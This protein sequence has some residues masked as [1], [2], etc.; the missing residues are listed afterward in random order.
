ME[1]H[2]VYYMYRAVARSD[3]LRFDVTAISPQKIGDEFP[4]TFGHYHPI[5]EDGLAYP[6]IYQ[7]LSGNAT[8][9]LQKMNSDETTDVIIVSANQG[10][11]VLLPPGYGHVSINSGGGAL[12][13]KNIVYDKFES[14]YDEYR[15]NRGAAIYY[16]SDRSIA[17]NSAYVIKNIERLSVTELNKKLGFS[18]K[19]LL[20]ELTNDPKKFEFLK[21]PKLLP[22]FARI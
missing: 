17:Q 16:L 8:F 3:D 13:L 7:V 20:S 5:G 12:V 18:C 10:D 19:D 6:E 21:S 11:R 15:K 2:D 1:S 9:I 22:G 14:N 4:K